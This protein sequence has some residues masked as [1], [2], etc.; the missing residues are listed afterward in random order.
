MLIT[1]G[2][3]FKPVGKAIQVKLVERMPRMCKGVIH[4]QGGYFEVS[5]PKIV[6]YMIPYVFF[7]IVLMSSLLFYNVKN[8]INKEN[9][10]MSRCVQ[11]FEWYCLLFCFTVAV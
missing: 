1:C 7:K 11:T 4:A 9:P 5:P 6:Y 3:A 10:G 8:S 2:N